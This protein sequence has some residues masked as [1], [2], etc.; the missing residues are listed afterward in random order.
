[1]AMSVLLYLDRFALTPITS[2]ILAELRLN[3]E[4]FGRAVGAFFFVYALCQV[5]AGW[6]SDR[7]GARWTL[8]LYVVFWSLATIGLG[9]A[10]GLLAISVMRMVL[11]AAQAG[12]YPAAASLLKRWIPLAGRGRANTLVSM[13]GRAGNLLSLF[14]TPAL[15]VAASGWLGWQSGGWRVV[16]ALYG[17]AGIIWAVLFAALYRDSPHEHP[18]CNDGERL[19]IDAPPAT[20][21]ATWS[22]YGRFL[23][24]LVTSRE[25]LL[26]CLI[27]V[28]VNIGWVFLVTWLPRYLIVHHGE[29]LG[30]YFRS[31]EVLAGLLTALPATAAIIGGLLGGAATD[32]FAARYGRTWGRR[33]PG[34]VAGFTVCGLYVIAT[35]LT[36]LWPF[37]AVMIAIALVIDFGLGASWA[38]FQ[39]IGGRQVAMTLGVGNMCGNLGAAYF[40]W[41]IGDLAKSGRWNAVFVIAAIAMAVNATCWL[42]FDASRP[43]VREEPQP[44]RGT[45]G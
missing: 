36:Q 29:E 40:G 28:S 41:Q 1:M 9:L 13:G 5:P 7:L 38:S 21:R 32:R 22:D 2:T 26:M 25:M 18:W 37:V 4:E 19:L 42:S 30:R 43:I 27:N 45:D 44:G 15:A 34:L 11:G 24:G 3:E 12:A 14:A 35:Q 33:L 17:V 6:L 31:P 20:A 16:L 8:A 23:R 10:V 39:D